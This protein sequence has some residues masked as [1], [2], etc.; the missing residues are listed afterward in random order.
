M[1]NK[2]N[3]RCAPSKKY[4]DGSCFN[5]KSLHIIANEYNKQNSNNKINIVNNKKQLLK[6]L[7]KKFLNKYNCKTQTCWLNTNIVKNTKNEDILKYTFR[8]TGPTGRSAWLSTIDINNVIDQYHEIDEQFLYLGTLP[9]NFL[10]LKELELDKVDFKEFYTDK[11][12]KLGMVI[13]LDEAHQSGSHWVALYTNLYKDQIYFFDS[14]GKKPRYKIKLF[15]NKIVNFLYEKNN[16]KKINIGNIISKINN[17]KANK[18]EELIN[19][20]N[21]LQNI[22]IRYNTKKHQFNDSE[23]GVYSINFIIRSV[24]G[25]SFDAI[26]NNITKDNKMN[27]C[28][29]TYFN[30]VSVEL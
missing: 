25:E 1:E 28:R 27:K 30:N 20:K 13:N 26:T 5:L 9:Y 22:D 6:E 29:E 7:H 18:E 19:L 4:E 21:K 15:I 12:Y 11:K 17:N 10:E 23:C 16:D 8:P 2:Y 3:K 14:V 24:Q